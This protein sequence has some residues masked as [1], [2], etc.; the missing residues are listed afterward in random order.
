MS[1]IFHTESF[2]IQFCDSGNTYINL[3][4]LIPCSVIHSSCLRQSENGL[5]FSDCCSSCRTIYSICL[6]LWQCRVCSCDHIP[7]AAGS[8]PRWTHFPM[9]SQARKTEYPKFLLLYWYTYHCHKNIAE[10]QSEYIPDLPAPS[11]PIVS[12]SLDNLPCFHR[13]T[14]SKL[15]ALHWVGTDNWQKSRLLLPRLYRK[16]S[17]PESIYDQ[18]LWKM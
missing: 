10:S 12:S 8:L 17:A 16:Y 18:M 13:S 2:L 5:K 15:A 6:D 14:G 9:Y 11:T 7:A 1:R 4:N 3:W